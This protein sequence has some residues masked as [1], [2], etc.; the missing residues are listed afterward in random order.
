LGLTRHTHITW[1]QYSGTVTAGVDK[2]RRVVVA[3]EPDP[4][5]T[6]ACTAGGG[7]SRL[8]WT[9]TFNEL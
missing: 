3:A 4:A 1:I 5:F 9:G 8:N 7:A 6:A 2:G